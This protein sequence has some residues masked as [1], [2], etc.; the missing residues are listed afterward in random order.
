[1]AGRDCAE[2]CPAWAVVWEGRYCLVIVGDLTVLRAVVHAP[3]NDSSASVVAY[4]TAE[5]YV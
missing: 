2:A 1:M 3:G 5:L 4:G